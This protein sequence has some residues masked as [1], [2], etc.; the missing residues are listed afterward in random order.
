MFQERNGRQQ[1]E[2]IVEGQGQGQKV[3]AQGHVVRHARSEHGRGLCT[4]V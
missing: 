1:G 4:Q 3:D 2:A